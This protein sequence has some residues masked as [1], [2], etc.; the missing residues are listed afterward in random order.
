MRRDSSRPRRAAYG[1]RIKSSALRAA[2]TLMI[3]CSLL[4]ALPGGTRAQGEAPS[5]PVHPKLR[6]L[7]DVPLLAT[8]AALLA[9]GNPLDV[10][11]KVVPPQGLSPSDIHWS[12]DRNAIGEHSTRADKESDYFRDA[13]VAYPMVLAF[14]SQ[15]SGMRASGT[16]RRSIVYVEAI[17]ISE[18]ISSVMK[19]SADRPRPYTYLP[20]N[21]RPNDPAYDVTS[22]EAFRSMPS[23]HSTIS[24]CA[25]GFAIADH[26]I[27]KPDASWRE[28]AGVALL[29]GFLAG[30]TAGMRMEGGQHFPSDTIV[31]GL[32]GTASG[33]T[34]PL[35]HHYLSADGRRAGLPS[36][37]AWGHAIAGGLVGVGI[38]V[39]AS[40][41]Y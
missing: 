30:M 36:A 10:T 33:I 6:W 2:A 7:V 4:L 41:L 17:M 37:R 21:E 3:V 13:A 24:F 40:E 26:L 38:G 29:G 16:L 12:L 23:G 11:R 1:R 35:V 31:G 8:G 39:L 19:N 20:A 28:H 25:A 15:P 5:P 14:I 34:V 9:I 32:I 22:D 27:S 18:G